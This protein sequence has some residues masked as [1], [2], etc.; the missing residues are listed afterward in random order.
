MDN[1]GEKQTIDFQSMTETCARNLKKRQVM[2]QTAAGIPSTWQIQ[3]ESV[4]QFSVKTDSLECKGILALF[5]QTMANKYTE[6]V[7]LYRIQNKKW[8]MQYNTYKQ[9]S[10]K[11]NT[12]RK[13]FHGCDK[14]SAQLII[15]SFF[16]RSFAGINGQSVLLS[17]MIE[18]ALFCRCCLWTRSLFLHECCVQSW[19]CSI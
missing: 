11:M 9:F 17:H 12:E 13:L 16:N 5:N 2:R 19:L 10:Q 1:R 3:A 4:A 18:T 8:Y 15:N 7:H 6:I 14:K